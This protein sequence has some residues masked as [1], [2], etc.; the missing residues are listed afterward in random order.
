VQADC[1][2]ACCA[3]QLGLGDFQAPLVPHG[4][5]HGLSCRLLAKQGLEPG[6]LR[7]SACAP[8]TRL[9]YWVGH[10]AATGRPSCRTATARQALARS[11]HIVL[12]L[13]NNGRCVAWVIQCHHAQCALAALW[14]PAMAREASV[15]WARAFKARCCV[16][17]QFSDSSIVLPSTV[18]Q[19]DTRM[20]WPPDI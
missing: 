17:I 14:Q 3:V 18:T 16:L 19:S 9:V 20:D 4:A 12:H 2:G 11:M 1:V 7:C 15:L 5:A 13:C 10:V 8:H 6:S